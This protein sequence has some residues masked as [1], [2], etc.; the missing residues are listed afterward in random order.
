MCDLSD[1][2]G[3]IPARWSS[4]R[5]PG[6]P[7]AEIRG[8]SMIEH[9]W[10]RASQALP[11]VVI[12]TDDDRIVREAERIGAESVMTSPDCING[13]QRV[14]E[15]YSIIGRG[16]GIIVD[17]QGDE[18]MIDPAVIAA[19][20]RRLID[21]PQCDIATAAHI[22]APDATFDHLSD[23]NRV[24]MTV[25]LSGEAL[26]FSRSVIP[27]LRGVPFE[28]WAARHPYLIHTGLYAFRAQTL[29]VIAA[30]QPS[31]LELC[32]GLEQLRWLQQGRR[33]AAYIYSGPSPQPVDTP[34][35]LAALLACFG[36][37]E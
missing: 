16:E 3:I 7:L 32:E 19:T 4:S 15:A 9:V 12:A 10:R 25:S 14:A 35:D 5:F 26:Y 33:I 30:S 21:S 2:I 13:T 27:Y 8:R 20:A 1:C 37:F 22:L 36:D 29:P 18:P 24:K 34:A 17:I 6:K 31:P 11:R 23:S 28:Q